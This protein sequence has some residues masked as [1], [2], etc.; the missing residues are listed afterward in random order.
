MKGSGNFSQLFLPQFSSLASALLL[1][2]CHGGLS[3]TWLIR[4]EPD[5]QTLRFRRRFMD[6]TSSEK[7]WI[8]RHSSPPLL[9]SGI[10]KCET[11][12]NSRIFGLKRAL[13]LV[14][15]DGLHHQ[16]PP[17]TKHLIP[18]N[19]DTPLE[20]NSDDACFICWVIRNITGP[21]AIDSAL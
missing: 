21:G 13:L 11:E 16:L 4:A 14:Y 1:S 19:V 20:K 17:D 18:A 12:I 2:V 6:L 3:L 8:R 7:P 9:R 5:I 10:P 15:I